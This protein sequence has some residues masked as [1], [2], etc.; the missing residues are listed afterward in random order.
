MSFLAR[1]GIALTLLLAGLSATAC[2]PVSVVS[3]GSLLG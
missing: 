1:I 2:T 3:D